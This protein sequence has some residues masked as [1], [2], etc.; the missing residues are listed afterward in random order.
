MTSSEGPSS[1]PTVARRSAARDGRAEHGGGYDR[2][3]RRQRLEI[4]R[5]GE[6]LLTDRLRTLCHVDCHRG[7]FELVT[8]LL[9]H[10]VTIATT[11]GS[12]P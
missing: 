5:T 4:L 11:E 1:D 6:D 2:L 12:I 7:V 3:I 8:W 9:I 10:R